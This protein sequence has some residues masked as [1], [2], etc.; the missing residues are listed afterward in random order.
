[1]RL[2]PAVKII[3][4]YIASSILDALIGLV[5]HVIRAEAANLDAQRGIMGSSVCKH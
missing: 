1:M 4:L 2:R 3:K 5:Q